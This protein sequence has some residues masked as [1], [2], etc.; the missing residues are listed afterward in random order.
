MYKVFHGYELLVFVF[1]F[2]FCYPFFP[3]ATHID[4]HT[5]LSVLPPEAKNGYIFLVLF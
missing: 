3:K 2:A 1:L 5:H 4:S